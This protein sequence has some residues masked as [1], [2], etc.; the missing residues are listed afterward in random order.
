MEKP[1]L[2]DKNEY[3]DD[4]VLQKYMGTT[5]PFWDEFTSVVST[6][7]PGVAFEWR[8]YNDGKAWLCKLTLKKKTMCW[9]SVW[10]QFFKLTFYFTEKT[11][12]SIS[13]LDIAPALKESFAQSPSI[14]RLKP[15]TIDVKSREILDSARIL[16]DYKSRLK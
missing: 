7:F 13:N 2:N 1:L 15:L 16:M 11:G 4:K 8:Y 10:D 5:K 14:G 3:P 6:E 9:I 12:A